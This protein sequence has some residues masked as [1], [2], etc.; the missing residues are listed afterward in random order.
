MKLKIGITGGIGSGKSTVAKIIS[1]SGYVVLD[2]DSIA[3]E[4]MLTD[5]SVRREIQSSFGEE[6]YK[7]GKLNR[8][9]L[10][11]SVFT[12]DENIIKI[13]LIVHPPTIKKINELLD[14]ELEKKNLAFV[15]AALIYES[16][17][18]EILDYVLLVTA[19]EKVR[20]NRIIN[21]DSLTE[22]Q[23]VSRMKFQMPE[24]EKENLADFVIK[25]ESDLEELERKTR[26][27]L[28]LFESMSKQ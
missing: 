25:N 2:A 6:A 22:Q 21:R 28:M 10:A 9:Y 16:E 3:K 7:D 26:F 5:E 14:N 11:T 4:I 15:E 24:D 8:D 17:M 13:N 19:S 1:N 18:D 20:I 27:F 23:I 12:S